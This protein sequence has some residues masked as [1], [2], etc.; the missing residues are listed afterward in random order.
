MT[1]AEG[2]AVQSVDP[3]PRGARITRAA[4]LLIAGLV[5][6]FTATLHEQF[7]FD[8]SV[9]AA[10]L[11][12]IG[13]VHLVEWLRVRPRT[14]ITL[15]LTIVALAAACAL[16][17]A[18]SELGYAV[19]VAVWALISGLLEFIGV[20]AGQRSRGDATLMGG[21]GIL[22]AA[23]VLLARED[24][25]AIL[26]FFG[27]YAVVGGVFLGISAFDPKRQSATDHSIKPSESRP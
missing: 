1:A 2:T 17:F 26:G 14:A 24:I 6:A 25:V 5:I 11:A 23:V 20:T 18:A 9:T 7:A 21:I 13:I 3:A 12:A 15:L 16:P 8:R 22:L 4:V 10:A 19:V 27:A